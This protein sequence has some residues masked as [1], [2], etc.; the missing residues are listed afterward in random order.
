MNRPNVLLICVDHWPGRLLKCAGHP[1]I[2]TPT[3]DQLAANGVR[4]T[5][6]YS[7]APTC[8]PAR[9]GLMT[10]TS[11]RTHG[12]RIMN[13]S[14]R[15]PSLPMLAQT[16]ADAGYQA[17]A[18]GKMHVNPQRSRIGFHDVILN[19][20]GRHLEGMTADDYELFL[21]AEGYAGQELTHAMCNN[22]YL[23]RPWHLPEY[24]HPTNWTVRE[25]CRVINRRDPT[26]PSLWHLSFNFPHPPLV[27]LAPYLDLYRAIEIPE[28]FIGDWA[29]DPVNL[30]YALKLRT[31]RFHDLRPTEL[32]LARQAFYAL[33][34]HIDH[35]L[36]LV[37][38]MLREQYLLDNTVILF[39]GDHGDMLGNHRQFAKG[40]FYEDSAKIPMILMPATGDRRVGHHRVDDR[41]A[42]LCDVMPTL[43]DLAGIPIPRTVEGLSLV[44]PKRRDYFYG[45]HYENERATRMIRDER[46]KLIYYAVGN[47]L[48]LFD[49]QE[50]P[51]EMRDLSAD[52]AHAAIRKSL[53]RELV[54]RLYGG[55]R[56]WVRNGQLVGLPDRPYRPSPNRDLSGQRGWR[57]R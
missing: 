10:G 28:P 48:Q 12:D 29:Q 15:T 16:F 30:P 52:P 47:R 19:E 24:L 20:E 33:C 41:L 8:I 56:K 49:L 46:C 9:L 22:E 36:R 21:D 39:T 25:M 3:L 18:V 17:Y 14:A 54:R 45:E 40:I 5:N 43:L 6:A 32:R 11:P 27:P 44:G 34:T 53:T 31:D 2:L 23:A 13:G 37:I 42:E 50:D 4:F 55:D 51:E 35:Q 57:F 7:A 38:G 1:C 26:R